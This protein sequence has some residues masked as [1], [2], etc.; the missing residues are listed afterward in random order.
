MTKKNN[1]QI[2]FMH[3]YNDFYIY[4]NVFNF[5]IESH[6]DIFFGQLRSWYYNE[7]RKDK[8]IPL[9]NKIGKKTF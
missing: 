1:L 9:N 4:E 3:F 6:F 8:K 7:K 2:V 5:W